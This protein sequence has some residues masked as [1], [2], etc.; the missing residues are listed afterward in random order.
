MFSKNT[1]N[2]TGGGGADW[3]T[4]P[5]T[6][7]VDMDDY[8][9]SNVGGLNNSATAT[10]GYVLTISIDKSLVWAAAGG[11]TASA[12]STFP[13]TQNVDM[14]NYSLIKVSNVSLQ[15]INGASYPQT[16]GTT[17]QVLTIS[18][19]ANTLYW[20][21]AGGGGNIADWAT[22]NAIQNVNLSGYSIS[23]ISN[24]S[25]GTVTASS[26]IF[27]RGVSVS[28]SITTLSGTVSNLSGYV[29]TISGAQF[30]STFPAI[31]NVNMSGY[32]ISN[33]SAAFI[34]NNVTISGITTLS[35][36]TVRN[37]LNVS[38]LTTLSSLVVTGD[39]SSARTNYKYS[40]VMY[41]M[42]NGNDTTG[43]GSILNPFATLSKAVSVLESQTL[44][45]DQQG[46]IYLGPG[47]F[48]FNDGITITKGYLTINGP[49]MHNNQP[50]YMTPIGPITINI[51]GQT[52][53]Y[54]QN[55]VILNG[56]FIT[57]GA[58]GGSPA[59]TNNSTS[60]HNLVIKNSLLNGKN[61]IINQTASNATGTR[62]IMQDCKV[63]QDTS[64]TSTSSVLLL[65]GNAWVTI[66]RCEI[67]TA[68]KGAPI[69][70]AGT[71]WLRG[72]ANS[73]IIC[74]LSSATETPPIVNVASSA[75]LL[76]HT[77]ASNIFFYQATNTK[78]TQ[79]ACAIAFT[80]TSNLNSNGATPAIIQLY[81]NI[82]Q[83][84]GTNDSTNYVLKTY[85]SN[86]IYPTN[87]LYVFRANN[88]VYQATGVS[89]A[90]I[91]DPSISTSAISNLIGLGPND[92]DTGSNWSSFPAIQNV[93][94]SGYVI[95][96]ISA[97]FISNNLNASG[98]VTV[99]GLTV[100]NL[101][102][103]G[104]NISGVTSI[105]GTTVG[106]NSAR[107]T[108]T[109]G[110]GVGT[111][112]SAS[113]IVYIGNTAGSSSNVNDVIA[114][115][116]GAG[117]SNNGTYSVLI[118]HDA[119]YGNT[120][121]GVN[122]IGTRAGV[123][124]IGIESVFIGTNA[125]IS[126]K[127]ERNTCIGYGAG[128]DNNG[129]DTVA[130]GCNAG[131]NSSGIRIVSIGAQA[132]V[133]NKGNDNIF[134]GYQPGIN[135]SG[136]LNVAMGF[137]AGASNMGSYNALLGYYAGKNN[138]GLHNVGVGTS[139]GQNTI[140]NYN[141]AAGLYAGSNI[142]GDYNVT[143]GFQAGVSNTGSGNIALGIDAG[144]SNRGANNVGVGTA[145]GQNICGDHNIALGAYA[146]ENTSGGSNIALGIDAGRSNK[147]NT[148]VFIGWS[149]GFSNSGNNCI[150]LGSNSNTTSSNTSNNQFI[151]Y[152]SI[153]SSPNF[154]QGRLD[155]NFLGINCNTPRYTLDVNGSANV[156]TNLL[157][158]Q[159]Q[160]ASYPQTLGTAGQVLT[161][162]SG[163]NTLYWA[164]TPTAQVYGSFSL[165][166]S[167]TYSNVAVGFSLDTP[168]IAVGCSIYNA[169]G[170]RVSNSGVYKCSYSLQLQHTGGGDQL[171]YLWL[172]RN[173]SN[174]PR[175]GSQVRLQG[176][177]DEIF[178]FCEYILDLSSNDYLQLMSKTGTGN[179]RAITDSI[180]GGPTVP[181][182]IFNIY[183]LA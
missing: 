41:V 87:S 47:E 42:S 51:T 153:W 143:L 167:L 78:F 63:Q 21:T 60:P 6:Q 119:G 162:S 54:D 28:G 111:H 136:I 4:F 58:T 100:Q 159:L 92:P 81:N 147:G 67:T 36:A 176:N 113:S 76:P 31:Q 30:W 24:V 149:A 104:S 88:K 52:A 56:L 152:S 144:R 49:T 27:I 14:N 154:L 178:P 3:S 71:T 80:N 43:T 46:V 98:L 72:L 120:A 177:N 168:E 8:D 172:Q 62:F 169:S 179:I 118:G 114:I 40:N 37:A 23:N 1:R 134:I 122:A 73:L 138:R 156:Q 35:S 16:L 94:M 141:T 18:S 180:A 107:N 123:F 112:V 121:Y 85:N 83:L 158:N 22:C 157:I 77:F 10:S 45:Y 5:A 173:G 2:Q 29:N 161:I 93:N 59:I 53:T 183:K 126:S 137:E 65:S 38:G 125:G 148:N 108:I 155:C 175:S 86:N 105:N 164:N 66:D 181:S 13:A 70:L 150:I 103:V 96:N 128:M 69:E 182:L 39:L 61:R 127:G 160:G 101:L 129:Q 106:I 79:S 115:G 163:T 171:V 124:N 48:N 32:S 95:S 50:Q 7:N 82:F 55:Q 34:S 117:I 102:T 146:G 145:A 33:I 26:D 139:A 17:G 11:G 151:V 116:R 68:N 131:L 74:T 99:S 12:W 25:T 109:I 84:T 110:N 97:A 90:S 135:S 75:V 170:I 91:I 132:G 142:T 9:F 89:Y 133:S 44:D 64:A 166:T 140:G 19:T 130:I 15:K 174:V 165:N 20:T 57:G